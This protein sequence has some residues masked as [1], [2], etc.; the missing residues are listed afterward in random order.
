MKFHANYLEINENYFR[1]RDNKKVK[2]YEIY[3]SGEGKINGAFFSYNDWVCVSWG[4]KGNFSKHS[5]HNI[6][7]VGYWEE[8]KKELVGGNVAYSDTTYNPAL[9]SKS[10]MDAPWDVS[11]AVIVKKPFYVIGTKLILEK[12]LWLTDGF[13]RLLPEGDYTITEHNKKEYY[14]DGPASIWLN[15]DFVHSNFREDLN[16]NA[17]GYKLTNLAQPSNDYVSKAYLDYANEC[18]NS[19]PKIIQIFSPKGKSAKEILGGPFP[20][21]FKTKEE[22]LKKHEIKICECGTDKHGFASHS[23]WCPKWEKL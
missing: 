17:S 19:D 6:D 18:I 14:V 8:P 12:D 5:E 3:E 1:T 22:L 2:I 9:H 13:G 21:V 11:S 15:K 4:L 10:T 23:D 16:P 20:I 7:I